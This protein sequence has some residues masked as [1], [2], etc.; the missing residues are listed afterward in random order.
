M[1]AFALLF[2]VACAPT[3]QACR[4]LMPLTGD[5]ITITST[6]NSTTGFTTTI[7]GVSV[8]TET[9]PR[10]TDL[11]DGPQRTPERKCSVV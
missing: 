6:P 11:G 3:E 8:T 7:D 1:K 2:L 4:A 5:A 9:P 10:R